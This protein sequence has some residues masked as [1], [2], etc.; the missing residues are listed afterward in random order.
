M[1][2]FFV[3][4]VKKKPSKSKLDFKE[5]KTKS[6]FMDVYRSSGTYLLMCLFMKLIIDCHLRFVFTEALNIIL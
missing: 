5:K 2:S 3:K 1:I 4:I 6:I